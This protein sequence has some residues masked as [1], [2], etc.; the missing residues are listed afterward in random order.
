[1]THHSCRCRIEFIWI[2]SF[3]TVNF[4]IH[5][6][7]F[8]VFTPYTPPEIPYESGGFFMSPTYPSIPPRFS[9]SSPDS[10]S[11]PI[12]KSA[13]WKGCRT[14]RHPRSIKLGSRITV[15]RAEDT[16]TF[17]ERM[18][19]EGISENCPPHS[20]PSFRGH[21]QSTDIPALHSER[22]EVHQQPLARRIP[23]DPLLFLHSFSRFSLYA[24]W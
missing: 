11:L 17:L 9:P 23:H 13:G 7:T 12:S 5:Y 6:S 4:P 22:H 10:R 18:S 8:P 21:R 16:R 20:G 2:Y 3:F 15:W 24:D 19:R 14:G 1:M